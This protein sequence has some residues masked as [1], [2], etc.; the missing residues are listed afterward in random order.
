MPWLF[1]DSNSSLSFVAC[2]SKCSQEARSE[3]FKVRSVINCVRGRYIQL[4]P[5]NTGFWFHRYAILETIIRLHQDEIC[6]V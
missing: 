2:I 5:N 3:M 1:Y 6:K 4:F